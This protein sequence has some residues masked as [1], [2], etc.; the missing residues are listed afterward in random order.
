MFLLSYHVTV[1]IGNTEKV[2]VPM[3]FRF[4]GLS[5]ERRDTAGCSATLRENNEEQNM[6]VYNLGSVRSE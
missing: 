1:L 4:S 6:K 3:T 5:P 2:A